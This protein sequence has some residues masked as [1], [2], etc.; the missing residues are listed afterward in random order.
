MYFLFVHHFNFWSS[1]LYLYVKYLHT[2]SSIFFRS[3]IR[4]WQTGPT[5]HLINTSH[6]IRTEEIMRRNLLSNQLEMSGPVPCCMP[7]QLRLRAKTHG[8]HVCEGGGVPRAKYTRAHGG[9]GWCL[10]EEK[11]E[12]GVATVRMK[13]DEYFKDR[14]LAGNNFC[15]RHHWSK[16]LW[17]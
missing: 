15:E 5:R 2:W 4:G 12:C 16:L 13:I 14:N 8:R 17:A 10:L 11:W 6:N 9:T 3:S 1:V 7:L